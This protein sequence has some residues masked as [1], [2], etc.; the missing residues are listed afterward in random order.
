MANNIEVKKAGDDILVTI[1][2]V[3][4]EHCDWPQLRGPTAEHLRIDLENI[5]SVNSLGFRA[6]RDWIYDLK[7]KKGIHLDKCATVFIR[8][9]NMLAGLVPS[10][11]TIESFFVPFACDACNHEDKVLFVRDKDFGDSIT[12]KEGSVP[13]PKCGAIMAMDAVPDIYFRFLKPS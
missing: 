12:P 5:K 1:G 9:L 13:C 7:A 2:G 6:W 10:R 8:Q 11:V 3:V 4:D